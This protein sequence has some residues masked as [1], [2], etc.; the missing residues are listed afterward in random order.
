MIITYIFWYL[1]TE[2]LLIY[3]LNK[4]KPNKSDTAA[5]LGFSILPIFH[6]FALSVIAVDVLTNWIH[7]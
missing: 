3:T 4:I 7:S 6:E 2:F 5:I 1:L